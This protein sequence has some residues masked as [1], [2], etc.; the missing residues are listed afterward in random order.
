MNGEAGTPPPLADDPDQMDQAV[1]RAARATGLRG[2]QVVHDYWL[3][4][5]LHAAASAAP[6]DGVFRAGLSTKDIKRGLQEED[7]P[8][9]SR[10]AF[11]GGT[12]LSAG[13]EISPR[14]SEDLDI[15]LFTVEGAAQSALR[16]ARR[17]LCHG[18]A[19]AVGGEIKTFDG[20]RI[21]QS[22]VTLPSGPSFAIDCAVE[23]PGGEH[24]ILRHTVRS[25]IARHSPDPDRLCADFP[26]VGGF[27]VPMVDPAYIA[28]NKLDAMHRR[29]A[30]GDLKGLRARFRDIFDLCHIARSVHAEPT[31]EAVPALW[32]RMNLGY[33]PRV[34]RPAGGYGT[35]PAFDAGTPAGRA[36]GDAYQAG[37]GGLASGQA[38]PFEEALAAARSLDLE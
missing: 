36:L 3:I 9:S 10:W 23:E 38:P 13:W 21:M 26:E 33:G 27:T 15:S 4:R 35:S 7:A 6:A 16:R 24:L 22:T 37:V 17:R 19:D 28:V 18:A 25:I 34:E 1:E 30:T 14:F 8:P 20:A 12:S 32:R 11:S 2:F 5:A 29:A 31:R